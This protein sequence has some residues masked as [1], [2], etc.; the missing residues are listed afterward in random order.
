MYIFHTSL[1][2]PVSKRGSILLG[3]MIAIKMVLDFILE[4]L[5]QKV[6]FKLLIPTDSQSSVGLLTLNRLGANTTQ[7]H[8][9]RY[10]NRTKTYQKKR[11]SS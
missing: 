1:K 11:D 10:P 3:E 7:K 4:K 6:T 9:K 2:Q 8:I 5:H